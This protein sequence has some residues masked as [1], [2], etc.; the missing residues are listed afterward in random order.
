VITGVPG[1]VAFDDAV[2][3][4]CRLVDKSLVVVHS[5]GIKPRYRLLETIRQYSL[6]KLAE[7]GQEAAA[8]WRHRDTFLSRVQ[9]WR[10]TPLGAVHFRAYLIAD[11]CKHK[12]NHPYPKH[13][14]YTG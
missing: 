4:L 10:G 9:T 3:L 1:G 6:E 2:D 13:F 11:E 7:A 14:L 12:C 5:E 8:R